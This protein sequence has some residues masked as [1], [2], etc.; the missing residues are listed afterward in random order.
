MLVRRVFGIALGC[1][2]TGCFADQTE[3]LGE[4]GDAGADDA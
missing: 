2:A 4:L 1:L 3:L